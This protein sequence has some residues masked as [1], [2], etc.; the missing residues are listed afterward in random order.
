MVAGM[1]APS[2]AT[3]KPRERALRPFNFVQDRLHSGQA[4][5]SRDSSEYGPLSMALSA[6]SEVAAVSV[7][8]AKLS[9]VLLAWLPSPDRLGAGF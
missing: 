9:K 3:P 4:F 2:R 8:Q 7:K 1:D 5:P 6:V